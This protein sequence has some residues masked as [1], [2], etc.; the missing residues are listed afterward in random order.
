MSTTLQLLAVAADTDHPMRAVGFTIGRL[1]TVSAAIWAIVHYVRKP[2]R[3]PPAP[4]PVMPPQHPH[5]SWQPPRHPPH[6]WGPPPVPSPHYP[7]FGPAPFAPAT[8]TPAHWALPAHPPTA[9][10]PRYGWPAA[11][12][13]PNSGNA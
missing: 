9:P 8:P 5:Q 2:R 4:R 6:G 1:L 3:R 10:T 12:H 7:P 13:D 11:A